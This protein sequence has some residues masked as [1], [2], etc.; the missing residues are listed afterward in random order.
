MRTLACLS[1]G[2]GFICISLNS[3]FCVMLG[4]AMQTMYSVTLCLKGADDDYLVQSQVSPFSTAVAFLSPGDLFG[5]QPDKVCKD[6]EYQ[7]SWLSGDA[8]DPVLTKKM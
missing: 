3:S 8:A 2:D 4:G 7:R 5:S 6:C 1:A